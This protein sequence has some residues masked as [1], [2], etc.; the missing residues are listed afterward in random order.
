[1]ANARRFGCALAAYPLLVA[2]DA[3]CVGLDAFKRARP[4]AQ[5][6]YVAGAAVVRP[7]PR[8]E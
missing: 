8:A 4:E 1:M 6:D 3:E 2:V 5:G 7:V